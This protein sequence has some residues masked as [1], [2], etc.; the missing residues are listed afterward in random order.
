MSVKHIESLS[1]GAGDFQAGEFQAWF[2]EIKC[3]DG[4]TLQ[5]KG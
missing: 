1:V 3:A 5:S 4:K 2:I